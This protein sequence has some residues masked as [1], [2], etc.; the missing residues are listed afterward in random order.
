MYAEGARLGAPDAVQVADRWHLLANLG[1]VTE[2]VLVRHHGVLGKIRLREPKAPNPCEESEQQPTQPVPR[3]PTR[4][5]QEERVRRGVREA[6][7]RDIHRL[8]DEGYGVR[9]TGRHL[10]LNPTTVRKYLAAPSCPH[11]SPRHGRVREIERYVPYLRE[12]WGRGERR[13][14]VL[15]EEIR[16]RGFGGAPRRV[17]EVLSPW[18]RELREN[19]KVGRPPWPPEAPPGRRI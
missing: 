15:W 14:D 7:Y 9:A 3:A 19:R 2:C 13:A 4:K 6:R 11:P 8:K 12:R 16:R 5:E 10:R 1:D 17:Q 18:R